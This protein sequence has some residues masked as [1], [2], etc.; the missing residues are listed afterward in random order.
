MEE[1]RGGWGG[2]GKRGEGD[3][4]VPGCPLRWHVSM[5]TVDFFVKCELM[6][7]KLLGCVVVHLFGLLYLFLALLDLIWRVVYN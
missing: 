5:E 1:V 4:C 3:C 6:P 2:E 7:H